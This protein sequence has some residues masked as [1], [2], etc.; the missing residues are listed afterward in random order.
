MTPTSIVMRERT[1]A[2]S[3]AVVD[4]AIMLNDSLGGGAAQAWTYMSSHGIGV[5][6][7]LRVLSYPSRRRT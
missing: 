1:D 6:I 5:D 3:A 4:Y 2:Q 7:I